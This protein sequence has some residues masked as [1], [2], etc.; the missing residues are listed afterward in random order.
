[1]GRCKNWSSGVASASGVQ[2]L[3]GFGSAIIGGWVRAVLGAGHGAGFGTMGC[4]G[5]GAGLGSGQGLAQALAQGFG[6]RLGS[7]RGE[8]NHAR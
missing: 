7:R 2:E 6:A 8:R 3:A 1:M 4:A 5:H